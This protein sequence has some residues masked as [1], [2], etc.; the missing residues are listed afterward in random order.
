MDR[1]Q[2]GECGRERSHS[3]RRASTM[4]ERLGASEQIN[5]QSRV[6]VATVSFYFALNLY[7]VLELVE[8]QNSVRC[9]FIPL[10]HREDIVSR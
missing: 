9:I 3:P 5:A 2:T 7:C 4:Y 1:R 10:H 6:L 8:E